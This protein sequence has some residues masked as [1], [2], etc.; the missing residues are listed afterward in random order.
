[1]KWT[2]YRSICL[3]LQH[4]EGWGRRMMSSRSVLTPFWEKKK[5]LPFN[6]I[7][8]GGNIASDNPQRVSEQKTGLGVVQIKAIQK[9][10]G[11]LGSLVTERWLSLCP[12]SAL[13][14]PEQASPGR[15]LC[16]HAHLL[17]TVF[18]TWCKLFVGLNENL[19]FSY[20]WLFFPS[21]LRV[22]QWL[23]NQIVTSSSRKSS[24]H[25]KRPSY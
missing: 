2:N 21:L 10:G 1:M 4:W 25:F 14:S 13:R 9:E 7:L 19:K 11:E 16:P 5:T 6:V 24:T 3:K 18:I 20:V 12:V 23:E 8:N 15:R 17:S 22:F